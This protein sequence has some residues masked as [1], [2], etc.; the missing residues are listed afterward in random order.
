MV[1]ITKI[2]HLF[3]PHSLSL[4]TTQERTMRSRHY[5]RM[6]NGKGGGAT[7]N[8]AS[9]TPVQKKRSWGRT[10]QRETINIVGNMEIETQDTLVNI[11]IKN[12]AASQEGESTIDL[13]HPELLDTDS[14]VNLLKERRVPIPVYENGS[15]SRERLIFL[16]R[17][18]VVPRPQRKLSQKLPYDERIYRTRV[19]K[20]QGMEWEGNRGAVDGSCRSWEG[21]GNSEIVLGKR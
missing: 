15:A 17:K 14:L 4:P 1:T 6:R 5:L 19:E 21:G 2:A 7:N 10:V 20:N 13:Q 9:N 12:D 3:K 8:M 16:F 11:H 18:H